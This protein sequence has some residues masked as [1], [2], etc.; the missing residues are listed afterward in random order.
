M[1]T[2]IIAVALVTAF[3]LTGC[4]STTGSDST[5]PDSSLESGSEGAESDALAEETPLDAGVTEEESTLED[6]EIVEENTTGGSVSQENALGSA[7]SYLSF[8]AFSR[9]GLIAQLE[10][11]KY[12]TADA[13]W[14][15]DN[16]SVDWNEQAARSAQSYLDFSSFSRSGLIDQLMFESYTRSQADYGV[17]QVGL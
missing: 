11:E 12:S 17:S 14:A 9:S 15:V 7:E 6:V 13:T 10:F 2:S 4:S 3:V 5:T 8:S 1:K 16:V